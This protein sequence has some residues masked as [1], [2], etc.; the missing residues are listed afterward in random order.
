MSSVLLEYEWSER[1]KIKMQYEWKNRENQTMKLNN[2]T[3]KIKQKE[4]K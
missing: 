2:K 4:E 1:I 3:K